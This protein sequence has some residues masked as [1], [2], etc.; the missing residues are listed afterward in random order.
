MA[1]IVVNVE[2]DQV[3]S[4]H[5][6]QQLLA[7]RQRHVD[8]GRWKWCVQEPADL[9][10]GLGDPHHRGQQH[11][12]VVM[13]EHQ[14]RRGRHCVCFLG[15]RRVEPLVGGPPLVDH[16]RI[17]VEHR[18]RNIVEER[19]E[20]L[21]PHPLGLPAGGSARQQS[22]HREWS[23]ATE[24]RT[25]SGSMSTACRMVCVRTRKAKEGL[26]YL[27]HIRGRK[28]ARDA[29]LLGQLCAQRRLMLRVLNRYGRASYLTGK[30]EGVVRTARCERGCGQGR[31]G[32][33]R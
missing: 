33:P 26:R 10:L 20:H 24:R 19:P 1:H 6:A 22:K 14:V 32:S 15:N 12:M 7:Q 21:G 18:E 30:C 13:D 5:A 16:L 29:V 25:E 11:Q 27:L 2:G 4:E 17:R 28:E 31:D 3:G 8:F 23:W 9:D